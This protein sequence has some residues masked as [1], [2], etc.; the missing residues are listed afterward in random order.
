MRKSVDQ[1]VVQKSAAVA[2][3]SKTVVLGNPGLDAKSSEPRGATGVSTACE[4]MVL[5][6]RFELVELLGSGGM[7][8][9]FKARDLRQVEAGD[10]DPWVA[11]K[12]INETF[13]RHEHA[14]VSLQQE[15]KK[16]QRLSHPNIVSA[17]DFDRDGSIAFMTMEL[18][19]GQ[20]L[21]QLLKQNKSGLIRSRANH[22]LR[23]VTDAIAYAHQQGIVHAD[24]KPANIFITTS[25]LVKILDFGI[26]RAIY[27]ESA[28]LDSTKVQAFTPAYASVRV[29]C[30][31]APSPQDDLYALGCIFYMLFAGQHPYGK[32]K[33]TQADAGAMKPKRIP[34]LSRSQWRAIRSLLS[35]HPPPDLS[36][37][38]FQAR[39]FGDSTQQSR[40]LALASCALLV[41]VIAGILLFNWFTHREHRAVTALLSVQNILSLE[42]GVRRLQ[43]FDEADALLI[44]DAA[45]DAAMANLEARLQQLKQAEDYQQAQSQFQ[46]VLPLYPDSS[47]M[48]DLWQRFQQQHQ[49]FVSELADELTL[50]IKQR[51]YAD[52]APQFSTLLT[53]LRR[54]APDH[55]VLTENPFK[56]LLAREAGLAIY[57]GHHAQARAIVQQAIRLY[58]DAAT[59]FQDILTRAEQSEGEVVAQGDT[60]IPEHF[61]DQWLESYQRAAEMA[62]GLELVEVDGLMGFLQELQQQNPA[63]HGVVRESL[64]GFLADKRLRNSQLLALKNGLLAKAEPQSVSHP[65]DPCQSVLANGGANARYRCRDP[66]TASVKGPELV[67]V[68]GAGSVAT[69]AVSRL[70]VTVNDYNHYCRLYKTCEPRAGD[71][72]PITGLHYT[73]VVDYLR[74]LSKMSGRRYSLPTIRQWQLMARDDSGVRDHNCKVY[75]GGRWVR[76]QSLRAAEVGYQN[77]LGLVNLFG[78]AAEWLGNANQLW[79]AGGDAYTDLAN[80]RPDR[81]T[82]SAP[83]GQALLGFRVVRALQ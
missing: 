55:P 47:A 34:E 82:G 58:P 61:A 28:T 76:G 20:S 72:L 54:V 70:E 56:D 57:L 45:R 67:V 22:I 7:G 19:P 52:T 53:D 12:V 3:V 16:T 40:R 4:G 60:A 62:A 18:L 73:E 50:R 5:K 83:E 78:N 39:Y 43:A 42:Q 8:S 33:A 13:C 69:F 77:S 64:Y 6:Q 2:P 36:V 37:E 79:A 41:M 81:I 27:A 80:C 23:Q 68:K 21:D 26:A 25:G 15:T 46:L 38:Y 51:R 65:R 63:M 44:L 31:A 49:V 71:E 14:L 10:A 9:V 24:L 32:C 35:F 17:Y 74:W 11:V 66:L 29:L 1:T 30:G 59:A 48:Q 75:A